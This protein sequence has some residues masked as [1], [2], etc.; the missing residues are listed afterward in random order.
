[1]AFFASSINRSA[2]ELAVL[3]MMNILYGDK[4]INE[5]CQ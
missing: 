3:S 5:K 1:M 4:K 2:C